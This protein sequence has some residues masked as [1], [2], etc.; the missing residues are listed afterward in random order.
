M[1]MGCACV[2]VSLAQEVAEVALMEALVD[3]A[4]QRPDA[5]VLVTT[6]TARTALFARDV[7]D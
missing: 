4:A 6:A 2:H 7:G 1:R 5:A 3:A